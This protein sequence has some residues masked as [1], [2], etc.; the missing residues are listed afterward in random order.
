MKNKKSKDGKNTWWKKSPTFLKVK[1][2]NTDQWNDDVE[3]SDALNPEVVS[4]EDIDKWEKAP[5]QEKEHEIPDEELVNHL[6]M[7]QQTFCRHYI[8]NREVLWNWTRSYAIAYWYYE[9]LKKDPLWIEDNAYQT[10]QVNASKLLWNTIINRYIRYINNLV[11]NDDVVQRELSHIALQNVDVQSKLKALDLRWKFN[12]KLTQ[13]LD[14]K[15][16]HEWTVVNIMKTYQKPEKKKPSSPN[17]NKKW[18]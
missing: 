14:A 7:K 5:N 8:W 3:V 17:K 13:K 9:R 12:W 16:K 2:I 15:V 18:Q 10:C 11:L 6:T 1:K 4:A